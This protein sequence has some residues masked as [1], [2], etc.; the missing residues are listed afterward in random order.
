MNTTYTYQM[1]SSGAARL[2]LLQGCEFGP[3]DAYFARDNGM[4]LSL[5]IDMG[6]PF[7]MADARISGNVAGSR[8]NL[9]YREIAGII[10]Q[11]RDRGL[12]SVALTGIAVPNGVP[13]LCGIVSHVHSLDIIPLIAVHAATASSELAEFL[14]EKNAS[15]SVRLDA[16][17]RAL[18]PGRIDRFIWRQLRPFIRSGF[19][20]PENL[21]RPRLRAIWPCDEPNPAEMEGFWHFCRIHHII[22]MINT[23]D[24]SNG[25]AL[26]PPDKMEELIGI[27]R[28]IDR[29]YYGYAWPSFSRRISGG[30]LC[31]LYS[32]YIT[33]EGNVRPCGPM[34]FD[35][36][37]VFLQ[38]GTYPY[39]IRNRSLGEI[40]N[41]PLF[42]NIRSVQ[43][44]DGILS[45]ISER[46]AECAGCHGYS[47]IDGTR[48]SAESVAA[49]CSDYTRC[50]KNQR[51]VAWTELTLK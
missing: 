34:A 1:I 6:G 13:H 37:S 33:G 42:R 28:K 30:C 35:K 46:L 27:P 43:Q 47:T 11:A 51:R 3:E 31:P 26:H 18:N 14:W 49:P 10:A 21:Q 16:P 48:E 44:G 20:E 2:P 41:D 15:V 17:D 32:L 5:N 12:R 50:S 23:R 45:G 25:S 8:H 22:P 38:N 36:Q 24:I 7:V 29:V 40:Y 39:N 19:F 9:S 4:L